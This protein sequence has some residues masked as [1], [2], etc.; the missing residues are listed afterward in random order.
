MIALAAAFGGN[1]LPDAGRLADRANT[2]AAPYSGDRTPTNAALAQVIP[3]ST[4][5]LPVI[6]V[7][8]PTEQAAKTAI[9]LGV[10]GETAEATAACGHAIGNGDVNCHE[11]AETGRHGDRDG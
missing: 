7:N 3:T 2:I 4:A 1:R 8:Q 11:H 10:G 6:D 5:T 9:A